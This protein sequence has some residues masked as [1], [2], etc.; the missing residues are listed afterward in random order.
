MKNSANPNFC[1][2]YFFFPV[3]KYINFIL[4]NMDYNYWIQYNKHKSQTVK[5]AKYFIAFFDGQRK[6]YSIKYSVEIWGSPLC[7]PAPTFREGEPS[8]R[9]AGKVVHRGVATVARLAKGNL[10]NSEFWRFGMVTSRWAE[11][12]KRGALGSF[13]SSAR[14]RSTGPVLYN[15]DLQEREIISSFHC[16]LTS[17]SKRKGT[18]RFQMENPNSC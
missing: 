18:G 16:H 11:G 10:S 13:V 1:F 15:A 7:S 6:V 17:S 12:L 14:K 3:E 8:A 2:S 4:Y 5:L 9:C